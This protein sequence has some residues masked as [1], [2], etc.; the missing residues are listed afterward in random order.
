[1]SVKHNN[2]P[3]SDTNNIHIISNGAITANTSMLVYYNVADDH[4]KHKQSL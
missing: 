4:L 2:N 3:A 1:M